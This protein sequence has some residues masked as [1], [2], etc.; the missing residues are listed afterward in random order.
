M[1]FI[2]GNHKNIES[3]I[4]KAN[5]NTLSSE[6]IS[7][8]ATGKI[9]DEGQFILNAL[10]SEFDSFTISDIKSII[11]KNNIEYNYLNY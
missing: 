10:S 7:M 3:E 9:K 1:S 4:K 5:L 11:E 2:K 8:L 6:Y